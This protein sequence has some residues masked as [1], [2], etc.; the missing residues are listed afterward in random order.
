MPACAYCRSRAGP[1]LRQSSC[2]SA[3]PQRQREQ[4]GL[5]QLLFEQRKAAG[6]FEVVA[7]QLDT[8]NGSGATTRNPRSSATWAASWSLPSAS[9]DSS[10]SG[11]CG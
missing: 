5:L 10:T 1:R 6:I 4:F 3:R 9:E 7:V 11:N 2:T 8:G